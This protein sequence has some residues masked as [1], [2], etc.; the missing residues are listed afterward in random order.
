MS[1]AL[2]P[3]SFVVVRAYPAVRGSVDGEVGLTSQRAR[4]R[5][6]LSSVP[7][8]VNDDLLLRSRTDPEAFGQF[9]DSHYDEVLGYFAGRVR[10]AETAADLC[11]ETFAAV[12]AGISRFD[13]ARGSASQ[14]LYGIA[15]HLLY[16]YWRDLRVRNEARDDL[17]MAPVEL[18]GDTAAMVARIDAAASLSALDRALAMLPTGHRRAVEL[19]V[20]AELDYAEIADVLGCRPGAAR[21]RVHRGLRRLRTVME[22]RDGG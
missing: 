10:S 5:D 1:T 4:R 14:W 15:R 18:D 7:V 17:G 11:S 13:P 8:N 19:R 16:R 2:P 21:V 12:L 20:L 22:E 9:F 6:P 3:A